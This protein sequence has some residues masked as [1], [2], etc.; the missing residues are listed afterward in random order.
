M[1][2]GTLNATH[3]LVSLYVSEVIQTA[4]RVFMNFLE[5]IGLSI[6]HNRLDLDDDPN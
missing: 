1:Y 6:K 5:E 2:S 3:S 4:G